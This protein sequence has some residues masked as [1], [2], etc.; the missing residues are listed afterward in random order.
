MPTITVVGIGPGN[1][2]L[3]TGEAR[4]ELLAAEKVFFRFSAH[5]V[6]FW[7]RDLGKQLVCFDQLYNLKWPRPG[8]I[9]DFISAA[10]LKE[11]GLREKVVY[12][13]PG[14]PSILEDT[15][16][17]LRFRGSA[18]GIEVRV[19]QGLSFLEL[20]LSEVN[21]DFSLGLQLVLPLNHVQHG[22]FRTD[23]PMI[24]CQIE[25]AT[26]PLDVPRVD[27][28]TRW[29]ALQ[30]PENHPVTLV[31]TD[32]LPDYATRSKTFPLA[33]LPREYGEGKYFASLYVPPK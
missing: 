26:L 32:G 16:R 13:V 31:W 17:L 8:A 6:Y 23:V 25:A 20:A 11:A 33:E 7:L 30:Y 21:L 14:S 27:L 3:L 15:T 4:R 24:V 19:I 28:T 10:L 12:A 29:L 5:P 2:S 18:E 1:L 22:L 9:Y